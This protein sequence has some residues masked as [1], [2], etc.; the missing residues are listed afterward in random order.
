[1]KSRLTLALALVALFAA[2][3]LATDATKTGTTEQKMSTDEHKMMHTKHHKMMARR[4][5]TKDG[6]MRVCRAHG[7]L[8]TMS[9]DGNRMMMM[10]AKGDVMVGDKA[11]KTIMMMGSDAKMAPVA[12]DSDEA[13]MFM[14]H[15]VTMSKK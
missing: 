14:D 7:C 5:R 4:I 3:A 10:S 8:M 15:M 6:T 13:K 9:K 2:P 1:M 11:T 12:A